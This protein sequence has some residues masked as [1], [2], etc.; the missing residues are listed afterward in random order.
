MKL[1]FKIF[2][3]AVILILAVSLILFSASL[4]MQD[5]VADIILKSLNNSISTK[6]E[7]KSLKLSFLRRFPKASVELKNVIIHSSGS[8]KASSLQ[9][10]EKDTLL[11]A[12]N[13]SVEFSLTDLINGNY[14]IESVFAKSGRLNL[15]TDTTGM[16][17]WNIS[18]AGSDKGDKDLAVSLEKINLR[19][20]DVLYDNRP[21]GMVIKGII[22]SGRLKSM[23][24]GENIDL[25]ALAHLN[26]ERFRLGNTVINGPINTNVDLAMQR[27]KDGISFS[28]GVLSTN[29]YDFDLKGSV[30]RG[31]ILDLA[32]SGQNIDIAKINTFLPGKYRAFSKAYEPSGILNAYCKI[33]GSFSSGHYPHIE[34]NYSLKD[35]KITCRNRHFVADNIS[36]S[37]FLSNGAGNSSTTGSFSMKDVSWTLGSGIYKGSL[38]ITNFNHPISVLAL[39]G[40]IFP[41]ELKKYF[42]IKQIS[43]A[44]G[45]ADIDLALTT[46]YKPEGKISINDIVK[47]KP[48]GT[49]IF[50]SLNIGF[51]DDT[52]LF[53]DIKGSLALKETIKADGLSL[54]YKGQRIKIYGDFTNF[55]EWL[56]GLPVKL[57]VSA[58][59]HMNRFIPWTFFSFGF[60]DSKENKKDRE[61]RLP[62]NINLN[63]NFNID[64][65]SYRKITC[66]KVSGSL[67]YRPKIFTFN[68]VNI[69]TLNGHVTGSGFIVQNI[70]R[71]VVTRGNF[72]IKNIDIN[73]AF[74]SFNN[75][76]QNFIKAENLAG[77]L[78]GSLS[79]MLPFDP[80]MNPLVKELTAEG[81][82]SLVKGALI[83]FNP[84]K[85]LS[86]FIEL[87]EL[88]N[89]HFEQ[90]QNDFFIKNN[91]LFMPQMDVKSSAADLSVNGQH[92]FDNNFEYH[93]KVRLSE[94]LSKKRKKSLNP[95]TEFG[96]VE[97]DGLGRTS[98]LLKIVN[99]GTD[100][101]KVSYDLKAAGSTVKNNIRKERQN[102]KTMLNEE[103]GWYKSDTSVKTRPVEKK[104]RIRITWDD[105]DTT[106][107]VP[108][109]VIKKKKIQIP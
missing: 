102:L 76:G 108:D 41:E 64:S 23:I 89:I 8:F 80:L 65:I 30:L 109:T 104:N 19:N 15:L 81:K 24:K 75:F 103:Y 53:R 69:N 88:E 2:K 58:D 60:S 47:L 27:S 101:I 22:K 71:T 67:N 1:V 74:N 14:T 51:N 79:L 46:A 49:I 86:S 77:T 7:Y 82:Y 90:L 107:S 42:N 91:T 11:A 66:S 83:D 21:A 25:I 38:S 52:L 63:I 5:K 85:Q 36:F 34:I 93:V 37:G 31:N 29:D 78:S 35:G 61:V 99:K 106:Y 17:N 95:V 97:D 56:A 16:V 33:K 70:N 98:L 40:K 39:K 20:I 62:D 28:K 73:R 72:I 43:S 13:L 105:S 6:F 84:V 87:S 10:R 54:L 45:S 59:I 100:D 94:I 44:E 3:L 32:L 55:P 18:E 9:R 26:I 4:I 50:N 12:A 48:E 68:S 92:D 96:A 57:S